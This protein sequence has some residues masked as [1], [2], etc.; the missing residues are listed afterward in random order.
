M[1]RDTYIHVREESDNCGCYECPKCQGKGYW[2]NALDLRV[3]CR[4]CDA[5]RRFI[6]SN[7]VYHL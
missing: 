2:V 1:R 3:P 7:G 5:G 4:Q 6:E